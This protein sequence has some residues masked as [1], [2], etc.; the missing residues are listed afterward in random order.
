MTVTR[1]NGLETAYFGESIGNQGCLREIC[2]LLDLARPLVQL[3][4]ARVYSS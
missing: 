3:M 2:H 4:T 1:F